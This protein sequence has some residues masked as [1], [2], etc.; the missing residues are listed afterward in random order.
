M[1]RSSSQKGLTSSNL[2]ESVY[3]DDP[4]VYEPNTPHNRRRRSYDA[5][6]AAPP[7]A[8]P[9]PAPL[10]LSYVAPPPVREFV[11]DIR[12]SYAY[13]RYEYPVDRVA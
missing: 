13:P 6:I 2:V 7:A 11:R 12:D 10:G 1:K 4:Y 5:R 8:I 3:Y 9:V